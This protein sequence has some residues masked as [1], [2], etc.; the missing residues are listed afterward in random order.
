LEVASGKRFPRKRKLVSA[1]V[2]TRAT[3]DSNYRNPHNPER[4]LFLHTFGREAR[5]ATQ[6]G[7]ATVTLHVSS[8]PSM[9]FKAAVQLRFE[10]SLA[11]QQKERKD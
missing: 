6:L 10:L 9:N 7:R 4:S 11:T 1:V 5:T 8:R 2:H 3:K